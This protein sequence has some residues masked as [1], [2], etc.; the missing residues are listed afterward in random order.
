MFSKIGI[1]QGRL[2]PKIDKKYQCFPALNWQKEFF[3]A[4]KLKIFKIELIFD[5]YHPHLNPLM[6]REGIEELKKIQKSTKVKV[7]S[8]C[9]D[10]FMENPIFTSN[11][12]QSNLNIKTLEKLIVNSKLINVK[13][14]ILP[15]VDKSSLNSNTRLNLFIKK[16]KQIEY[17]LDKTKI[18][19]SL[20]TDLPPN[21]FLNLINSFRSKFITINYDTGNSASLGFNPEKELNIYGS[22]IS[23]V[24]IKDRLFKGGPVFFGKGNTEF[25]K[26]FRLLKKIKYKGNFILQMY[27]D[28]KGIDVFKKQY[29]L[30]KLIINEK[31]N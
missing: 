13:N 19:L 31:K 16:I 17:L 6:S 28:K 12:Y 14:I 11:L 26:I 27:R 2:L 5:N 30:L 3:L 24:H 20:E 1:M 9:A 21:K 4:K 22:R 29:N 18:N 10:Y 23:E 15:C 25:K 8:V 7:V